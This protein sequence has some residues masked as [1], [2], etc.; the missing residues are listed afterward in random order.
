MLNFIYN[1]ESENIEQFKDLIIELGRK[2]NNNIE[3][4]TDYYIVFADERKEIDEIFKKNK[5]IN[6]HNCTILTNNLSSSYIL[7]ILKYTNCVYYAKNDIEI[8][9]K[10]ILFNI[11]KQNK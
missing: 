11:R 3:L 8:T 9:L 2:I 1:E 10:K 7:H 4:K 5:S 6:N